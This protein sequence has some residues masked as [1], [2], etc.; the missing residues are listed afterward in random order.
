MGSHTR[1]PIRISAM[2]SGW[3]ESTTFVGQIGGH[4]C[5]LVTYISL[6]QKIS[7]L[8]QYFLQGGISMAFTKPRTRF[9]TIVATVVLL[10]SGLAFSFF[11]SSTHAAHAS[12]GGHFNQPGNLLITDQFNN[13]SIEVDRSTKSIVWSF[14]SGDPTL[15]NPGPGTIIGLNDAERVSGGLTIP[16]GTRSPPGASTSLPPLSDR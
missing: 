1:M 7:Y 3:G 2:P 6:V 10:F 8:R 4:A 16:S 11:A 9:L 14:G 5:N 12:R 13:R 15:C